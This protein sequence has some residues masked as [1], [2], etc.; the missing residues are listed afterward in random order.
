MGL[1]RKDVVSSSHCGEMHPSIY[2]IHGSG[3]AAYLAL[4]SRF[5]DEAPDK[6]EVDISAAIRKQLHA[7]YIYY[8]LYFFSKDDFICLF[9]FK[10]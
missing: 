4:A 2:A 8:V 10:T 3:E 7:R 1:R 9:H 6:R 5:G